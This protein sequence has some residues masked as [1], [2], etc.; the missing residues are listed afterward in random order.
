M[1]IDK[2]TLSQ[3]LLRAYVSLLI[4][5]FSSYQQKK[6]IKFLIPSCNIQISC[7]LFVSFRKDA[8]IKRVLFFFIGPFCMRQSIHNF[9]NTKPSPGCPT[10]MAFEP[11]VTSI[12]GI[13]TAKKLLYNSLLSV[14]YVL[15][16]NGR[17]PLVTRI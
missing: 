6:S 16:N 2:V 17:F 13:S 10:F 11:L 12:I 7:L 1:Y 3:F 5:I 9:F 15:T 14:D 8:K 4:H